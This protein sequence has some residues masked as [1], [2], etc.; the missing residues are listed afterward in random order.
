M[1]PTPP[2]SSGRSPQDTNTKSS[3]EFK[4]VKKR[5]RVPLSCAPCRNR[6][7]KCNRSHPCENC[8]RRGD[9]STCTYASTAHGSSRARKQ[10]SGPN[11]SSSDEMQS[12]IDRLEG[13]VLKLMGSGGNHLSPPTG[14]ER[15]A[16]ADDGTNKVKRCDDDDDDDGG[17]DDDDDIGMGSIHEDENRRAEGES[18]EDVEEVRSALGVM[19]V[20]R[21]R[22]FYRGETH[23]A[24]ILSEI[25]EVKNFFNEVKQ[26]WEEKL[27]HMKAKNAGP[28]KLDR[29]GFPFNAGRPPS[30]KELLSLVPRQELVDLLVD[31]FFRNY[32]PIFHVLHRPTFYKQYEDFWRDPT[33]VDLIWLGLLMA[34]MC[35]SLKIYHH[36]GEEPPEISGKTQE[37]SDAFRL[38]TEQC[39]IVG[40]FTKKMYIHTVQAL[41]LVCTWQTNKDH[42]DE[43]WIFQGMLVRIAMCMGLHRDPMQFESTITP[44]EAEIRRRIWTMICCMDVLGSIKIGLPCMIRQDECDTR[45]PMN[46]HDDEIGE[47]VDVLPPERPREELTGVSYMIA[48]A[49]MSKVY[50][51]IVA[52]TSSLGPRPAYDQIRE[53]DAEI[54]EMHAAVPPFLRLKPTEECKDDPAWLIIQRYNLDLIAHKALVTL[55]RPYAARAEH[56]PRYEGSRQKCVEAALVLLRHQVEIILDTQSTL[57]HARWFTEGLGCLDFLH[58]AMI[59]CLDLSTQCRLARD[60]SKTQGE[61]GFLLGATERAEQYNVLEK[62]RLIYE[63]QRDTSI[64]ATKAYGI[65]TVMLD[66]IRGGP[67]YFDFSLGCPAEIRKAAEKNGLA[68]T[69]QGSISSSTTGDTPIVATPS[70]PASEAPPTPLNPTKNEVAAMSLSLMGQNALSSNTAAAMLYSAQTPGG[71]N[72]IMGD[73]NNSEYGASP[74]GGSSNLS[75]FWSQSGVDM[76]NGLD[77]NEWDN[78]M[79]GINLDSNQS[80]AW[81]MMAALPGSS[82]QPLLNPDGT[83]RVPAS[84]AA[85]S[86][87]TVAPG[88]KGGRGGGAGGQAPARS[89]L[90]ANATGYFDTEGMDI[91]SLR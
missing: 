52:Q 18:D 47:G 27:A 61:Q 38:A 32:D 58:A 64:D 42:V 60:R 36:S 57:K 25:S 39:L 30:R 21:G 41:I 3:K 24:A 83:Y 87:N 77:W 10:S 53:M 14:R 45:L 62:A 51:R 56:N 20:D 17:D 63:K 72:I 35:L 91:G 88:D 46:L 6:K 28:N 50:S 16:S 70:S 66:K 80:P 71:H 5:N 40:E 26:S 48:K 90:P 12:R 76:P 65:L 8:I 73:V 67:G 84:S 89:A 22:S 55:H 13:L 78:F 43:S 11:G 2:S 7:L 79:Q 15:S 4:V 31:G 81:P 9:P 37:M 69:P 29:T 33:Q 54:R 19:K 34:I 75:Q 49:S 23:W 86:A 82:Q 44:S 85:A 59:I 1:T 74:G 68:P